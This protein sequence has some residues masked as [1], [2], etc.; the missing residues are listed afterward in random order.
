MGRPAAFAQ[1]TGFVFVNAPGS[2]CYLEAMADAK[3]A[4]DRARARIEAKKGPPVE[5]VALNFAS[6]AVQFVGKFG[7]V[8]VR[9]DG[10]PQAVVKGIQVVGGNQDEPRAK[11]GGQAEAKA[12][13]QQDD[14]T[15]APNH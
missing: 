5:T 12:T 1:P 14:S 9:A 11:R 13:Q 4:V 15:R 2:T 7:M 10:Q 6:A 3:R 8:V